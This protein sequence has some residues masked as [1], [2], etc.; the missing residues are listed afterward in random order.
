MSTIADKLYP[1]TLYQDRLVEALLA[2]EP[3]VKGH[4]LVRPLREAKRLSDLSAEESG[5][6]FLVASYAAAILF[7]G[8]HAE[9][10]NI[11]VEEGRQVTAHVLARS[12]DDGLSFA[13]QPQ[14][15]DEAAMK[16]AQE[17]IRDKT[18]LIG[19][20]Q[21]PSEKEEGGPKPAPSKDEAKEAPG[22]PSE[23]RPRAKG[24]DDGKPKDG[25]GDPLKDAEERE[26]YLIKQLIRIP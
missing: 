10:T 14:K 11:I 13:W 7:Q 1:D 5:H 3:A 18:F 23:E 21:K 22:K 9:G 20:R 17:R 12:S 2:P 4:V 16:D 26:N 8:I 24:P 25:D 19:K 6:L 15:L